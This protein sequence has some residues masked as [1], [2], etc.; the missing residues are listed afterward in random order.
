[1]TS[2]DWLPVGVGHDLVVLPLDGAQ[3]AARFRGHRADIT[4]ITA[5]AD[6]A[7]VAT[8]DE[9][10]EVRVWRRGGGASVVLG[11]WGTGVLL[12]A[13][14]DDRLAIATRDEVLV[15]SSVSRLTAPGAAPLPDVL[16]ALT[17][18]VIDDSRAAPR[19]PAAP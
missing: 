9:A 19:S 3:P 16:G 1:M 17:S 14:A 2:D 12:S 15:Y 8:G 13:L 11:T 10:G 6:G 4:A 5:S 7:L 18:A